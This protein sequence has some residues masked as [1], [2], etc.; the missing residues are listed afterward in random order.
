MQVSN[1]QYFKNLDFEQY[2]KLPGHSYSSI[3]GFSGQPTAGMKLGTR[4]HNYL[5]EPECFDWQQAAEVRKIA[6]AVRQ[7]LGDAYTIMDKELSF[8][9]N[10][11]Y[12]DM[13]LQ[14][15]GRVDMVKVGSLVVDLKVL[16]GALPAAIE[17]FGYNH[18]ISGYCYGT[19][20]SRGLII[21]YNKSSKKIETKFINPD[22]GFWQY[23]IARLGVP[24]IKINK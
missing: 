5:N 6:A 2:L 15:R 18:Q 10:L 12:E 16:S 4:V 24:E 19:G 1:I 14:Y 9:C 11:E 8:T 3:K 17:R 13:I 7:Y 23:Q 20:A 21:A 22:P